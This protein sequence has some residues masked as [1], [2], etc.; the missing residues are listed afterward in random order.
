LRT[1]QQ[2]AAA[3]YGR[4]VGRGAPPASPPDK[5]MLAWYIADRREAGIADE[6]I[7][8]EILHGGRELSKQ[9][10]SRLAKFGRKFPN[11]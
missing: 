6:K 8:Q 4:K 7:F 2:Y 11:T 3:A 1:A 5:E 10:F 9:E